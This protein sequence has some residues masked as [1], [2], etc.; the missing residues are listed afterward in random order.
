MTDAVWRRNGVLCAV[1]AFSMWGAF[2]IYFKITPGVSALE[3]LAHR[4]TWAVP[5]GLSIVLW[6]RQIKH[7]LGIF[8]D[9]RT[10]LWL[11]LGAFFI[12]V[13]WLVYTYAVQNDQIFQ[14]SLGYYINP[15]L[16]VLAGFLF[17]GERLRLGQA[18]AVVVASAG[19]MVLALKGAGWPWLSLTLA[20]SFTVYGFIRKQIT[21]GAMPALFVETLLLLPAAVIYLFVLRNRSAL[22][23]TSISTEL[24]I[25]LLLAGPVT[26]LPLLF[27]A[28]GARRLR[29]STVGFLQFIGP[30]GQFLVGMAY[31]ESMTPAHALCFGLI[32]TAVALFCFDAWRHRSPQSRAD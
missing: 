15:L 8:R 12:A 1:A 3:M 5:F 30:T 10:M 6:R 19:V 17:L 29:L 18:I 26:V 14:A 22:A 27:F 2:P 23:F 7:V 28:I 32:W 16:L 21:V 25:L 9:R 4:I 11:T 24:D 31:G 20:V 13:N